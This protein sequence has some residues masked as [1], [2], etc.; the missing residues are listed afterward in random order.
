MERKQCSKNVKLK[1]IEPRCFSKISQKKQDLRIDLPTVGLKTFK[2]CIHNR[3]KRNCIK[4]L[5]KIF[6]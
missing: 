4:N 6:F 1:S 5:D 2:Q 3:N